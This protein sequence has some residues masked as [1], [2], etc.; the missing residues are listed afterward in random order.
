[1]ETP[2]GRKRLKVEQRA[3]R[4]KWVAELL[5]PD[6]R[7]GRNTLHEQADDSWCCLGVAGD[8][9]GLDRAIIDRKGLLPTKWAADVLGLRRQRTN[10]LLADDQDE[11]ARW[12]D[13]SD[14]TFPQIADRVALATER[15]TSFAN[16]DYAPPELDGSVPGDFARE[17]LATV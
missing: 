1:M 14:F 13:T 7:Q 3:N 15:K 9:C 8:V 16:L 4:V 12:N 17:W 2:T 6:R 5:D 10:S 11:A